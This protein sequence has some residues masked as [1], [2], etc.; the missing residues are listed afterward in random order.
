MTKSDKPRARRSA[1]AKSAEWTDAQR[2]QIAELAYQRFLARGGD[3]GYHME[4][5]LAAEADMAARLKAPRPRR[6]RQA[7][8]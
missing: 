1:P 5:W 2:E 4:D 6:A 8:A 3:H 7:T